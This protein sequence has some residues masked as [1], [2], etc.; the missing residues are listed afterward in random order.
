MTVSTWQEKVAAKQAE[1][2]AKIPIEW[3]LPEDI[4]Q[5]VE[6]DKLNILDVPTKCGILSDKELKITEIPDATALRDKLAAGE[7]NAAEVTTAFCKRAAVAQQL[8]SCLTETMFPQALERAKELDAHFKRTGEPVGP[9]HGVPVSL[10][11]TFNVQGVPSTLGYV[12]FL[13]RPPVSQNSAL[14]DILLK[15]GAVLHVKTNV[16]QT[17]MTADSHNNVFGRVLNPNRR[18]L[19]AG[20][21]SGGEGA[22]VAMRGTLLGIGTDIAGSIRIPALCCGTVGFKPSVGRV[23]YGGQTSAGRPGMTG[24]APVAGPLCH[25]IRDAEMLLRVVFNAP[26]DDMDDMALAFP[27]IE[28]SNQAAKNLRIGVLSE[29]PRAPLHPSIQRGL[30]K[31]VEKL[32][33]AGHDIVALSEQVNFM[34]TAAD[35][36]FQFFRIDP[37]QT[38]VKHIRDGGEPCIP[39]LRH[40]Y[41]LEGKSPEPTL[42]ELFDLN[43]TKADF[44]AR[45]RLI[46]LENQLDV[47]IGPGNQAT[48]VPHDTYGLPIYTVPANL[49]DVRSRLTLTYNH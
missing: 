6:T 1:A 41:D 26:A 22:L 36:A 9:L 12:S 43:V 45:M 44:A 34:G 21:S 24:I 11:E 49:V 16:P 27:W 31:A 32:A 37:D 38:Q 17:M 33:S 23:P 2:W 29:D 5:Q 30:S 42:R 20:G 48:A 25:S 10:K 40:T 4:L 8:T 15:A 39:S 3:R 19:T 7:L 28:P 13:D 47:I 18:T 14:V 35:V 46:F